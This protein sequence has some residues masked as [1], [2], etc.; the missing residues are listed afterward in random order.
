MR[1]LSRQ[2]RSASIRNMTG[3][4]RG[5][6]APSSMRRKERQ[7][8]IGSWMSCYKGRRTRRGTRLGSRRS[9]LPRRKTSRY[10]LMQILIMIRLRRRKRRNV[11]QGG[12]RSIKRRGNVLGRRSEKMIKP[13]AGKSKKLFRQSKGELRSRND[14]LRSKRR[15]MRKLRKG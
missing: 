14:W 6:D 3:S 8:I 9:S 15:K 12:T 10:S 11:I 7:S 5:R 1:N 4:K 2:I 13:I